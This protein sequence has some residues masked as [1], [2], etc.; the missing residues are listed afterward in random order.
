MKQITVM[1]VDDE[2]LVV[3]DLRTIVDWQALGFHIVTTAAN[4]KQALIKFREYHPQ[5]VITDIKMPFM[6]GIEL[7]KRLREE[8]QATQILLLTAYEDFSYAK[9]AIRY[10]INDYIIKGTITKESFS[11]VLGKLRGLIKEQEQVSNLLAQN[12]LT[13]FFQADD[14]TMKDAGSDF[15]SE[16][17]NYLI[18]EQDL[19]VFLPADYDLSQYQIRIDKILKDCCEIELEDA[20]IVMAVKLDA[21]RILMV[22]EPEEHL[23]SERIDAIYRYKNRFKKNLAQSFQRSFTI[24]IVGQRMSLLKFKELYQSSKAVFSQKYFISN[25]ETIDLTEPFKNPAKKANTSDIS[26]LDK[27]VG[28][29]DVKEIV[30]EIE[31]IFETMPQDYK[32]LN[33]LAGEMYSL[34]TRQVKA[35]AGTNLGTVKSGLDWDC[36]L[37]AKDICKWFCTQFS[38]LAD[39]R[40]NQEFGKYSRP[41][42]KV[43]QYIAA[44]FQ[45]QSLS[46][47]EIADVINLSIGHLSMIFKKE[48][49]MT[50]NA[51]ITQVRLEEAKILLLAGE[52]KI[53]EIADA[54]GYQTGQ[55]FSQIFYKQEGCYPSE[56]L[57]KET[58]L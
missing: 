31:G 19:P 53:Y 4:G 26:R 24:Y 44:N 47:K 23:I 56:Y 12:R 11:E 49:G 41:V 40:K 13:E 27:A 36:W 35:L 25:A 29:N 5:V 33:L 54:V 43:R 15:T 50:L 16:R 58:N 1:I 42:V 22:I 51:Y 20:D 18:I 37:R 17:Y 48:T 9:S 38:L 39:I 7:I 14:N 6:D 46:I 2:R 34:L 3:E 52:K 21:N 8:N 28:K 32:H 45:R 30:A 57:N 10:G 55:Y